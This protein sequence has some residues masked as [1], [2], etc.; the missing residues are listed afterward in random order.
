[1]STWTHVAGVIRVNALRGF[2][3]TPDFEKIFIS[4][5]C[6]RYNKDCNMPTGSEGS[7]EYK[8][9]ENPNVDSLAAYNVAIWGDLRDFG[10]DDITKIEEWWDR[11]LKQCGMIRQAVLQIEPEDGERVIFNYEDEEC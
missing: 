7:L 8:I 6:R 4:S 5:T 10:K 1:M 2:V 11:V 9:L 3:R